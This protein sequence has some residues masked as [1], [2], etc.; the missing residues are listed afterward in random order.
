MRLALLRAA[1]RG[2]SKC[3]YGAEGGGRIMPRGGDPAIAIV[4][5]LIAVLAIR[6][7][8]GRK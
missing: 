4:L 1:R 5:V 3:P 7:L 8:R 2:L 6:F